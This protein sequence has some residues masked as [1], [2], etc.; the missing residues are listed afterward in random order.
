MRNTAELVELARAGD[1][2]AI[3]ALVERYERIAV[4]TAMMIVQDFHHAQ[5]I[6][7]ESFVSAFRAIEQL[8]SN[9]AFGPWLL[10]AVRRRAQQFARRNR[11]L[12]CDFPS[13][14]LF[15]DRQGW[16]QELLEV[17]PL[18]SQLPEHE[19]EV[20]NLRYLNGY[21]VREVSELTERPV[22]TVT[23]QLSRAI[24]RL[25][26]MIAEIEQ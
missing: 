13:D 6:A 26:G 7:Q 9:E 21:S 12:V 20:V 1:T 17:L 2:E 15:E 16:S 4:T 18:L 23:K 24:H 11:E 25:R 8:R 19:L 10:I 3:G 22:G 14:D 5:D